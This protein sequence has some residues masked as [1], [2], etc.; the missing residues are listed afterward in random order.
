M[1]VEIEQLVEHVREV[2]GPLEPQ[3]VYLY[4]S[5]AGGRMRCESDLDLAFLSRKRCDPVAVFDAAQRIAARAGCDVDLVDLSLSPAV[6]R[7]QVVGKG[8]RLIVNDLRAA[9][10]FEMYALSDYARTNEER[11][12]VLARFGR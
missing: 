8:R 2:L 5:A 12:E 6:F 10:E 9:Q 1:K 3:V 4:G 11:R 7:A